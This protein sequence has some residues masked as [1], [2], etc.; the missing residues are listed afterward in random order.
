MHI[1]RICNGEITETYMVKEMLLGL[2]ESF[3]YIKCGAC[4]CLQIGEIP[5]NLSKYYPK[6][7]YSLQVSKKKK[8][9]IIRDYVRKSIALF[10]I[11]GKGLVGS[12]LSRFKAP[13]PMHLVYRR[14]GLKNSDKILDVGGGAGAHAS[15]LIKLGVKNVMSVDPF[16]LEDVFFENILVAKKLSFY[17]IKEKYDL[18]TFH[19]SL[20]H[21]PDQAKVLE[22]AAGL[23]NQGG[24]ILIRVPTVT[25]TAWEKYRE[26]WVNLD[27]PRHFY[28][29][30]HASIR[31]LAEH[32]GLKVLDFWN[33]SVP[34]Q[35]WGSEQY[36][37][38]IPLTDPCSYSKDENS[39][40]FSQHQI[41]DYQRKTRL[42]NAQEKG[43]WMCIVLCN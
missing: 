33:D 20:E 4:G 22:K 21:M 11:Q 19:H 15:S 42:L 13:D 9:R 35:F 6:T 38:D 25:S 14:V 17:E 24:R 29:H 27:A 30:S 18:I 37:K 23:I 41:L 39:S 10:N 5:S 26:N 1:C 12:I 16:I 34:M 36:L 8:S 3:Q 7:Y 28:L 31:M 43:D 32:A 2:R 40:I